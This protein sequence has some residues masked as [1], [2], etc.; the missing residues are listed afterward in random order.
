MRMHFYSIVG[1][2]VGDILHH[3]SMFFSASWIIFKI[4]HQE[5]KIVHLLPQCINVSFTTT[6]QSEEA[7]GGT[8]I[9]MIFPIFDITCTS[10]LD[11]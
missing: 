4:L 8:S 3:I 9:L 10:I 6:D 1:S 7:M 2:V 11:D 5:V